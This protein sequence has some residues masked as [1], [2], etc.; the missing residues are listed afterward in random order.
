MIKKNTVLITGATGMIGQQLITEFNQRG[1]QVNTLSR[2]PI[3][4]VGVKSYVWNVE[5]NEIDE[6]AV[7]TANIILH[8]AGESVAAKRWTAKRK[9][10]ILNS[11]V[12]STK[13]IVATLRKYN[14]HVDT[15]IGASAVGYY[16]S[17]D[18]EELT[19]KSLPQKGFLSDV[20]VSWEDAHRVV[21]EFAKRVVVYRIGVVLDKHEGA[22]QEMMKTLPLSL[23]YLGNGKQYMSFIYI[24]DL[25][26]LFSWATDNEH[27]HGTFNAVS[28]IPVTNKAFIQSLSSYRRAILPITPVPG[29]VLK[30]IMGEAA[31][32]ALDSQNCAAE[33]LMNAGFDFHYSNINQVFEDMF[34]H[35]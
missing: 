16:G 3:K 6:D 30:L 8:I 20:C 35:A 12:N 4:R 34:L 1:Y 18:N 15:Y 26:R 23:N 17:R 31:C 19:E 10:E 14:H 22:L 2:K 13:L 28:P 32:I 7:L 24:K 11:R 33:K 5:R 21:N 29:F 25:I 27:I 9:A